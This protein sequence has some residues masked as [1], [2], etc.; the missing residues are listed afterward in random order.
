VGSPKKEES[1]TIELLTHFKNKRK[2]KKVPNQ[3]SEENKRKE[4][5][6]FPDQR[7]EESKK[8]KFPIKDW[9]KAKKKENFPI[10][11]RKKTKEIYRKVFR[12]DNI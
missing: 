6:K 4:T 12:P 7:S 1:L 2:K 9:K 10:E 8:R 11:D 5:K 3:R